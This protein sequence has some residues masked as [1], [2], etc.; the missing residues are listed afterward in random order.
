[1]SIELEVT[2]NGAFAGAKAN[3]S[4]YTVTENATPID[5]SD[6]RGGVG[7]ISV[8]LVEDP[9]QSLLLLNDTVVL[10]DSLRG[11]V[12]GVVTDV[13][14]NGAVLDLTAD[15]RLSLL[16]A[17]REAAA[18]YGTLGQAFVY[19]LGLVGLTANV[20]VDPSITARPVL[21]P[22]WTGPVWTMLKQMCAAEQV[23][24]AL[25]SNNVVLRPI[26]ERVLQT[27]KSTTPPS[28]GATQGELAQTIEVVYYDTEYLINGLAY[29]Y[30]GWSP[31]NNSSSGWQ[32]DAGETAVYEFSIPATLDSI[33]QPTPVDTVD[34]Y[35]T[36]PGS[37]YAVT[38]QD[39]TSIPATYWTDT[40]GSVTAEL[41][42][43]DKVR[44]TII[45]STDISNAPYRIAVSAGESDYYNS[46]FLT[47]TGIFYE[48]KTLVLPTG[49]P[50]S[51]SSTE[52]GA[53]INSRFITSESQAY[54]VGVIAAAK[55]GSAD[56]VVSF[57]TTRVN[58]RGED[59]SITYPTFADFNADWPTEAFSDFTAVWS[60]KTFADFTEYYFAQ[61]EDEFE[62]QAFGNIAGSRTQF[63]DALYRVREATIKPD[64]VT[65]TAE[66]DTLFSE[67]N[68]VWA[69]KTFANFTT[70]ATGMKFEDFS[71]IPLRK[72]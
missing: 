67:F 60:G 12:G 61:V 56:Q 63:R 66:K 24:I 70:Y 55:Y 64:T 26:R 3:V 54:T 15:S 48:E 21:Y 39:G 68:A 45:G 52:V 38:G 6:S 71:L 13:G 10:D 28:W 17:P 41:L 35:Y 47:G 72:D 20:F 23:E 18:Q 58:K 46:L 30:G 31:N 8:K 22:G 42:P 59:G 4:E 25:V 62:N 2:G 43:G 14:G 32:I 65:I 36:G 44:V 9:N 19:Y 51:K 27:N 53:T 33:N 37:V 40:G 5:P 16:L 1:M 29:P 69:G 34:R 57:S 7:T 11:T 49:T 50:P